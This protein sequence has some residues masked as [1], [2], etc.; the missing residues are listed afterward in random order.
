LSTGTIALRSLIGEHA[1]DFHG[2]TN[3]A[4][5]YH[6]DLQVLIEQLTER[7]DQSDLIG[8]LAADRQTQLYNADLARE[9]RVVV[10]TLRKEFD[11]ANEFRVQR[12]IDIGC[13]V[14][15]GGR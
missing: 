15:D 10:D 2:N 1:R 5:P 4:E 13:P 11:K 8:L 3:L 6:M 12:V 9:L 14:Q 7:A